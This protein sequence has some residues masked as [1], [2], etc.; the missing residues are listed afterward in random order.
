MTQ[1]KHWALA[2]RTVKDNQPAVLV[3]IVGHH[4][5]VPGKTGAMMVVTPDQI[6]GTVGG[7]LVEHQL[8]ELA[9]S[10]PE[11]QILPF[12]HD[13]DATDSICSGHQTIAVLPLSKL[14]LLQLG[15]LAE[16]EAADSPGM[17]TLGPD[18]PSVDSGPVGP[19][20]LT[21]NE[22]HW[23][24]TM[25]I[26]PQDTL[27][28][29]GGGHVGLALSRVM[30]ALP[31]RI[32][33]LDDRQDLPTI[34]Q[35]T[36]AHDIHQICWSEVAQSVVEGDRSWVVIMTRGHRH[37]TEVLKKL[38]PLDIHYLGMMGSA[39]KV[40]QVFTKMEAEGLDPGDLKRVYAP[41]GVPISSHTPEE[42]AISIAAEII[43]VR[44]AKK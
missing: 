38:L 29:V 2:A 10:G 14:D 26:G 20:L 12:A 28:I 22:K 35:N 39:A 3:A 32:V 15:T 1:S 34:A 6:E 40:R 31:F 19:T 42:I 37:D 43:Q 23:Q 36:W 24:F 44:N 9:R 4:G 25:P 18:G 21:E 33:I 7:G 17:L 30:A 5:S 41:I 16:M 8:I 13:G 11:N 27:T